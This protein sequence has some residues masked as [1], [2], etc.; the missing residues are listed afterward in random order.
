MEES[1]RGAAISNGGRSWT[2]RRT[3]EG[4]TELFG[5]ASP[6]ALYLPRRLRDESGEREPV[7]VLVL[8]EVGEGDEEE[9]C[10]VSGGFVGD[11]VLPSLVRDMI[12]EGGLVGVLKVLNGIEVLERARRSDGVLRDPADANLVP[13]RLKM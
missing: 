8:L 3:H 2:A 4:I 5:C 7:V 6:I 12:E 13:V 11:D 9:T 1:C 10:E